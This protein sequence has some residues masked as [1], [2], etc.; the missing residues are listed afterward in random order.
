MGGFALPPSPRLRRTGSCGLN[1]TRALS[2]RNSVH[3]RRILFRI[4][5]E[6]LFGGCFW[7]SESIDL[8]CQRPLSNWRINVNKGFNGYD[9]AN[10]ESSNSR[11]GE[12]PACASAE[13]EILLEI[14][15]K[16]GEL[17]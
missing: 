8:V 16:G 14:P 7:R 11:A 6:P 13:L 2:L 5:P 4:L 17:D 1:S 15:D 9:S 3:S 10:I 12:A